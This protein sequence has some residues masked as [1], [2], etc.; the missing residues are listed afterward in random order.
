MFFIFQKKT[1]VPYNG[2]LRIFKTSFVYQ[3]ME[4]IKRFIKILGLVVLMFLA[5]IGIGLVGG[6]PIMP[7]NKRDN[8]IQIKT[9]VEE[10]SDDESLFVMSEIKQ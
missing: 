3:K 1:I 7:S 2:Y 4:K 8:T 5:S 9:E 10:S 6:I